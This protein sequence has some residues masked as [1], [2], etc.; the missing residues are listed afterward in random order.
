MFDVAREARVGT[1]TVSR[2]VNG[3]ELVSAKALARVRAA[4]LKLDYQPNR[5]AQILKGERTKTIGLIVPSVT[6]PFYAICTEVA[7]EISRAH[8]FLLFVTCSNNAPLIDLESLNTL[9][10]HQVEGILIAP[11]ASR[12]EELV[13][14]LSRIS[15]PVVVFDRLI[16][17]YSSP[18]VVSTNLKGAKEATRHLI[19]H[20]YKQILC[21]GKKEDSIYTMKERVR[22]YRSAMKEA[23]LTPRIDF[24]LASQESTELAMKAYMHGTNPPDA[25]FAAHNLATISVFEALK[26]LRI[27]IPKKVALVGFDDF[28]LASTLEPSITVVK[29]DIRLIVKKAAELLFD[30]LALKRHGPSKAADRVDESGYLWVETELIVRSS[31]GCHPIDNE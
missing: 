12:N 2:V 27:K 10:Q 1:S 3:G 28:E 6:D 4:I 11:A 25:I 30:Q 9:V 15:I 21:L 13:Q 20:G 26:S 8:G 29:Q 5:A 31:C 24:T 14:A 23:H 19:S 17:G 18:S 22:G 16:H 7:Q